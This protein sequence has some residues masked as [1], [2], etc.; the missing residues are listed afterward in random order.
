MLKQSFHMPSA[1][2]KHESRYITTVPHRRGNLLRTPLSVGVFSTRRFLVGH[3]GWIPL[4]PAQNEHQL[5][6]FS[7][8]NH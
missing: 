4:S 2:V 1:S 7:R 5:P 8:L 6:I 3:L